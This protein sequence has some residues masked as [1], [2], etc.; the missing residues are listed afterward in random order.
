MLCAFIALFSILNSC[1]FLK[2]LVGGVPSFF[3][4]FLSWLHF[5]E[6]SYRAHIH[7]WKYWSI[8]PA[9]LR[10]C[11]C[12]H[13]KPLLP[14][15]CVCVCTCNAP[16]ALALYCWVAILWQT[17]QCKAA[18]LWPASFCG[19]SQGQA[20]L[21]P[22]LGDLTDCRRD[23]VRSWLEKD[24]FQAH[25]AVVFN[26]CGLSDWGLSV[27]LLTASSA[28]GLTRFPTGQRQ[29]KREITEA[30]IPRR[31]GSPGSVCPPHSP[32]ESNPDRI[33]MVAPEEGSLTNSLYSRQIWKE[34]DS[35]FVFRIFMKRKAVTFFPWTKCFL[36]LLSLRSL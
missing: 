23:A 31:Q 25:V 34:K 11:K 17:S 18:P 16:T 35:G 30:V 4:L 32:C 3:R 1:S 29:Q 24:H 6:M 27:L 20:L 28:P 15:V 9:C 22:L 21:G 12:G 2:Y 7:S 36:D 33:H 8:Y 14:C 19:E 10:V 5:L 26:S 13:L